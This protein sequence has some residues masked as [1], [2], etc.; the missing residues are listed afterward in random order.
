MSPPTATGHLARL[1]TDA[2]DSRNTVDGSASVMG[3]VEVKEESVMADMAFREG[4]R[5]YITGSC[6]GLN[7]V[8]EAL[9]RHPEIELVGRSATAREGVI[10][11]GAIISG[12]PA[13]NAVVGAARGRPRGHP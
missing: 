12:R 6:E 3:L 4:T 9:E 7:E 1:V 8:T 11:A 2:A 13:R 5:I 10:P